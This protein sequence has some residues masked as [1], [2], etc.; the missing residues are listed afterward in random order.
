MEA[1]RPVPRIRW[2]ETTH[3]EKANV[4]PSSLAQLL[5]EYLET[6]HQRTLQDLENSI[7]KQQSV[8]KRYQEL[9]IR[10][11]ETSK[12]LI[13][14]ATARHEAEVRVTKLE[15]LLVSNYHKSGVTVDSQY[16]ED[17]T[18]VWSRARRCRQLQGWCFLYYPRQG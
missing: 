16:R 5:K 11:V 14:E 15:K 17:R 8:K 1:Y 18:E 2:R 6:L 7:S 9:G 13:K 12:D 4:S 3:Q 10:Y